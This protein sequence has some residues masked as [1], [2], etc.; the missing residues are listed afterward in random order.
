LGL[1]DLPNARKV[2]AQPTPKGGGL[3]IFAAFLAGSLC[4]ARTL[5]RTDWILLTLGALIAFLGLIDDLQPLSWL[6]RLSVQAIVA[7][8]AVTVLPLGVPWI[9]T[10]LAVLWIVGL[11]NAFNMLDNMDGLSAGVAYI[12]AAAYALAAAPTQAGANLLSLLTLMG[13]VLGFLWFNL[14]PARIFMGDAG[15]TFLGFFLGVRSLESDVLDLGQTQSWFVPAL[16]FAI[17][18]YDLTTVVLLR[19]AQG[20]S[21]FHADKQH[22]SHRLVGLGL[23]KRASVRFIHV[24]A[25]GSA[26]GAL[27]SFSLRPMQLLLVLGQA[28][29]WWL[30]LATLEYLPHLTQALKHGPIDSSPPIQPPSIDQ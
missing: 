13:A 28:A 4:L 24:L 7:I 8:I 18:L 23:S 5:E 30:A 10:P 16:V 21:P 25:V 9:A 19:M 2:H 29:A 3:A 15:S 22:L 11:T 17:P 1:V 14:P 27:L 20:R 12:A 6:L 26:L